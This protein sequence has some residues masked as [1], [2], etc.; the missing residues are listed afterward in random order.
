ME[1]K[2]LTVIK[3]EKSSAN[4][5]P[6]RT[7]GAHPG[8]VRLNSTHLSA[9]LEQLTAHEVMTPHPFTV[10]NSDSIETALDILD[11]HNFRHLPVTDGQGNLVGI[12]SDRDLRSFA[13][14][15]GVE[16]DHPELAHGRSDRQIAT[17]MQ[18]DVISVDTETEI[19]EVLDLMI[20]EKIG[21]IPVVKPG[22]RLLVG[23]VSYLDLL[24][25]LQ[26]LYAQA[27]QEPV[28]ANSR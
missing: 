21:S 24:K 1:N 25:Q 2:N 22:T 23:I 16:L 17:I 4:K 20:Q 7:N 3:G 11:S 5:F 8:D 10:A 14:P 27:N 26:E 18:T 19:E 13:L 15:M 12:V 28:S 6:D 9:Q